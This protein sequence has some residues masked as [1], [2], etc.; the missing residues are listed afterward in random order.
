MSTKTRRALAPRTPCPRPDGH[1][2]LECHVVGA[3]G[4]TLPEIGVLPTLTV[5]DGRSRSTR[6]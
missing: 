5:T 6:Q 4:L 1:W 2:L 3:G